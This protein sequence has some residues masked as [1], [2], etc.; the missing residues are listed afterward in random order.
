MAPEAPWLLSVSS[1][2]LIPPACR[3][4]RCGVCGPST[5]RRLGVA[6]DRAGY[7]RWITLPNPPTDLRQ[8]VARLANRLRENGP[9]EWIWSAERGEKR[10]RLHAHAMIRSGWLDN[11]SEWLREHCRAAG[12]GR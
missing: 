7:D 3:A 10:G 11:R 1:G 6:M 5:A 9:M 12:W 8:G 4:W 2:A